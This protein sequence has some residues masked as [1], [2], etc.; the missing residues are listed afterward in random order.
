MQTLGEERPHGGSRGGVPVWLEEG[1][2]CELV[3]QLGDATQA[4]RA[5]Q[6]LAELASRTGCE[7]L[8]TRSLRVSGVL[9]RD[10]SSL[11][12]ARSEFTRQ[13]LPLEAA[14][15]R[16]RLAE[17][18]SGEAAV[19]EARTALAVFEDLGAA[20]D[21]DAAAARLRELGVVAVRGGP[22]GFGELTH[23]EREVLDLLGEGLSNRELAVRL[24]LS[25]KTVER[26]VR[27][28]LLKLGLRNRAE[29]AAY[30]VRHRMRSTR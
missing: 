2:L 4:E 6:R 12:Q 23:R 15:T 11:E 30:V 21:A 14:R 25:R 5:A 18:L 7:Q 20:R 9:R 26:H 24:F 29:A 1:R 17:L 3:A 10:R 13:R 16:M 27:N 22:A 19:A 8:R 28:V